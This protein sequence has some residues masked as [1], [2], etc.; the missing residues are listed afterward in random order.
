MKKINCPVCNKTKFEFVFKGVEESI[1]YQYVIC[2]ECG[3]VFINPRMSEKEYKQFYQ[4]KH[5]TEY[6]EK[7]F[8]RDYKRGKNFIL[9]LEFNKINLKGKTVL[10]IGCNS[11]GILKAFQDHG[12]IVTGI[13]YNEDAVLFGQRKGLDLKTREVDITKQYDIILLIH[14]IEHMLYPTRSLKRISEILLKDNGIL[15]IQTPGILNL[16]SEGYNLNVNM[17]LGHVFYFSFR[18]LYNFLTKAGF[19]LIKADEGINVIAV[20]TKREF[21]GYTTDYANTKAILEK[22]KNYK[23]QEHRRKALIFCA[24][25]A[26]RIAPKTFYKLRNRYLERI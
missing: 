18:T 22:A 4:R 7:Q 9:Y 26:K 11:G 6:F 8:E 19:S 5:A 14:T 17:G 16:K 3:L 20:N 12:A 13:D 21:K 2:K 23:P 15:F 1:E 10:D 25:I 24:N